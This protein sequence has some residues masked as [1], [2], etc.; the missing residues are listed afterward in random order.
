ME[1]S[2]GANDELYR[3]R[4]VEKR[5]GKGA[6]A[7][8]A[9]RGVDLEIR[10]G[11]FVVVAGASGAGKSTLLQ[12]LGGLDRASAG[13]VAFEG[14]DLGT[15]GDDDLAQLRLRSFGFVFQQFNLIPTLTAAENIEL[16][17]APA[18]LPAHE[19]RQRVEALLDQ[20]GLSPRRRHL[21]GQL[22]GGEQQR[23]AIAR[24]LANTPH[25]L[26]AD[27]PTGNL[28]S[29]TGE[30]ILGLLR[31]LVDQDRRTVVLVTHDRE[32]AA[33]APVLLRM[34]DGKLE[35]EPDAGPSPNATTRP[36]S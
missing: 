15:L 32:I 22:S 29:T 11:E 12:L 35:R 1:P 19:R 8:V 36:A 14:T 21:P 16:A 5:Y 3:L 24:A 13:S 9:L 26:L 30:G 33:R 17:L 28:D 25:V 23:V 4:A 27:E 34:H 2:P 10:S 18:A 6:A 7:V 20:V 31:A